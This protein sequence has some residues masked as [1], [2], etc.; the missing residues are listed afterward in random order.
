MPVSSLASSPF[1]DFL[2]PGA[3]LLT[4]M[5]VL[6]LAAASATVLRA[7]IAPLLAIASG[8]LLIGWIAVEMV[9]LVSWSSLVW[10]FYLLLGAAIV[11]TGLWWWR[12]AR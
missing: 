10:T 5:G 1:S 8:V 6:P 4:F 9:I 11:G 12:T 7:R 3:I 2:V